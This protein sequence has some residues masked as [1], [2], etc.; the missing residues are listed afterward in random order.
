[1]GK[2]KGVIV[3]NTDRCKGCSLCVVACPKNVI[4]LSAK[5]VN[6]MAIAMLRQCFRTNV[7]DARRA[8]LYVLTDV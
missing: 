4:A 1:M 7:S 5:A 6:G 8:V 3:V 2:M